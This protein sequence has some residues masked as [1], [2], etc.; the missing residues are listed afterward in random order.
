AASNGATPAT[1]A[2][3]GPVNGTHQIDGDQPGP[4]PADTGP[5]RVASAAAARRHQGQETRRRI[6]DHIAQNPDAT[7]AQIAE[8]VGKSV[9]TVRRHL[10]ELDNQ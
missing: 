1:G 5:D 10:T 3:T 2:G 7:P 4:V 9:T 8:A 6:A